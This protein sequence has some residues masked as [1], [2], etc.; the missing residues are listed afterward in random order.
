MPEVDTP[1]TSIDVK[2]A[3]KDSCKMK[4]QNRGDASQRG[5][6]MFEF[7]PSVTAKKIHWLASQ[8]NGI[9]TNSE[10]ATVT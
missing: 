2:M 6:H 7:H 1:L 4:W 8:H 10:Q 3:V 5:K 9:D